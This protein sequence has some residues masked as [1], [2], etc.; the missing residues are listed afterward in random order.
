MIGGFEPVVDKLFDVVIRVVAGVARFLTVTIPNAL[1][2]V[3]LLI[4]I[5]GRN[6]SRAWIAITDNVVVPVLRFFEQT[7]PRAMLGAAERALS[8]FQPVAD[9]VERITGVNVGLDKVRSTLKGASE[10]FELPGGGAAGALEAASKVAAA[11]IQQSLKQDEMLKERIVERQTRN[12]TDEMRAFLDKITTDSEDRAKEQTEV[13]RA[14]EDGTQRV[15][16]AIDEKVEALAGP[17]SQV[18]F[19]LNRLA[20]TL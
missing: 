18:Y 9:L 12:I 10:T 2:G 13:V 7:L 6:V 17:I 8:V 16:D 14:I 1:D 20:S 19:N 15:V 3:S 5:V 11:M 4:N